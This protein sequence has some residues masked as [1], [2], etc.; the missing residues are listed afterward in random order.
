[1]ALCAQL[2]LA[3]VATERAAGVAVHGAPLPDSVRSIASR[4]LHVMETVWQELVVSGQFAPA[5]DSGC[6]SQAAG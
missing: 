2:A 4:P 6:V 3:A 5:S 1:M